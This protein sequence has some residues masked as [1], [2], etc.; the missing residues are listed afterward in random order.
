MTH[1]EASFDHLWRAL[2]G[3][4]L[5]TE[6]RFHPDRRWRFD[7]AHPEAR[8]AIEIEGGVWS[9]GRHV[10]PAGFEEDCVKYNSAAAEGWLVFRVTSKMLDNPANLEAII[11]TIRQYGG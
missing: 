9:N 8:V 1:L 2:D 6:Y 11:D 7:R 10:R 4:P 5:E 3:Q